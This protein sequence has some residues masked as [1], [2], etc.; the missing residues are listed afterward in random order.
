MNGFISCASYAFAAALMATASM[1]TLA[2]A[3]GYAQQNE[4][5]VTGKHQ[6]LWDKGVKLEAKGMESLV[7]AEKEFTDAARD[8]LDAQKKRDKATGKISNASEEFRQLTSNVPMFNNPKE[9]AKWADLVSNAADSWAKND[10][11]QEDGQSDLTKSMK[12]QASAQSA[13]KSAQANI[14]KGRAMKAEAQ[15]RSLASN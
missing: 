3:A 11:R 13:V 2:N 14:D 7:K 6:K 4:I 9:A 15:Q 8:V 12:R 10:N 5:V 1:P